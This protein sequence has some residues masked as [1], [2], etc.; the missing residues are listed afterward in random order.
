MSAVMTSS[1]EGTRT[2]DTADMSRMLYHLSYA[3]V[4]RESAPTIATCRGS[5]NHRGLLRL[6]APW[7]APLPAMPRTVRLDPLPAAK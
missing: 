7:P 4:V 5:V 2:L 6:T 3:A 1:G